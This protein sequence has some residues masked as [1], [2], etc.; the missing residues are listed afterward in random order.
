MR[1]LAS[2]FRR[3]KPVW[4]PSPHWWA[5]ASLWFGNAVPWWYGA[6][7]SGKRGM[8]T[9]WGT[10]RKTPKKLSKKSLEMFRLFQSGKT[11]REIAT[12]FKVSFQYVSHE[13]SKVS[14][15]LG[16][17]LRPHKRHV[18]IPD[19][20]A[21]AYTAGEIKTKAE[22]AEKIGCSTSTVSV[23]VGIV[24]RPRGFRSD[25]AI[26]ARNAEIYARFMAGESTKALADEYGTTLGSLQQMLVR[27][28][29]LTGAPP[30]T[31]WQVKPNHTIRRLK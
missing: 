30:K 19:A 6:V 13:V 23:R 5:P 27:H 4:E 21:A 22:L 7:W 2:A 20:L 18:V 17:P 28:R 1:G 12:L 25:P 10:V 31:E 24:K 14:K 16:E 3:Q 8:T 9:L 15:R 11:A 29:Q 26:L